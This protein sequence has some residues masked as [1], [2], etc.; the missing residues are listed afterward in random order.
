[1]LYNEKGPE[2]AAQLIKA[3]KYKLRQSLINYR[4]EPGKYETQQPPSRSKLSKYMM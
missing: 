1:M 4:N 2:I 3:E